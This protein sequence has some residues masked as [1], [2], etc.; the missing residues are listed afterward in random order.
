VTLGHEGVG[1]IVEIGE[2]VSNLRL[3]DRVCTAWLKESCQHCEQCWSGWESVCEAQTNYGFTEDGSFSEYVVSSAYFCNKVPDAISSEQAVPITCAGVTTYKALKE[4][5]VRAGEW[6]V[7]IGGSGGLGHVGI[8]YAKA[9]GMRVLG[10]DVGAEK[11]EFMRSLGCDAV[12]DQ[13]EGDVVEKVKKVTNGG[14]HGAI[15]LVP[16]Q[17]CIKEAVSYLRRRGTIVL[18]AL[19]PGEFSANT[20]DVVLK[21][22]TIKG[23]IVGTRQDLAEALDLAAI[24]K[25]KCSIEVHGFRDVNNVLGNLAAGK[26]NG[27]IV[28][29]LSQI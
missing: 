8:Q 19:P 25:I 26:V 16:L 6:I 15:I 2:G 7:I 4:S 1:H 21:A 11:L 22:I 10:I 28:L 14:P 27:R 20:V 24:G 29:D 23:S 18:I 13:A 5:N 9:M 3:G 17:S 12:I